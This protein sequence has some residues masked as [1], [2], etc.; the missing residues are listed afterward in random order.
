MH[1]AQQTYIPS[2]E[3]GGRRQ[4]IEEV[5]HRLAVF[6]GRSA[7]RLSRAV[8]K[9]K[10]S[11]I[12]GRVAMRTDPGIL[13]YLGTTRET[14]LVT[15]TNGKSTTSRL[16]AAALSGRGPVATGV[17][18]NRVAGLVSTLVEAPRSAT[19]ALETREIDACGVIDALEP[20]VVILLNLSSDVDK[21]TEASALE[22]ELRE[23]LAAHPET[24]L[25]ANCDDV[26]IASIAFDAAHVVWVAAGMGNEGVT[27]A[28]PRC[29]GL[30][31]VRS[32]EGNEDHPEWCCTD[33]SF[34]R[35]R[36]SWSVERSESGTVLRGPDGF[37]EELALCLPGAVNQ[38]NAAQAV[39]AAAA[40]GVDPREALRAVSS[41]KDIEQRYSRLPWGQHV[42]RL[43]LGKNPV[44]AQESVRVI[45]PETTGAVLVLNEQS[46]NSRDTAWIWDVDY[47]TLRGLGP[48]ILAC[49][50]RAADLSV[51]LAY[52]GVPHAV[53]PETLGA[54]ASCDP[55]AVDVVVP[56]VE[57]LQSLEGEV[58]APRRRRIV[59]GEG[60]SQPR[61]ARLLVPEN[62]Q[63]VPSSGMN[64]VVRIGLILPETL[65]ASGDRGNALVL[66]ERLR[67]RGYDAQILA[68]GF[69][70]PVPG[71]LD[72]YVLGG[73][74]TDQQRLAVEHLRRD[75]GLLRAIEK[76]VPV[77][78]VRAG[79]QIL[80]R[81]FEDEQG[82]RHD[83]LGVLDMT[84]IPT[85]R[86][87]GGAA[88]E[89]KCSPLLD[90]LSS[91]LT[92]LHS[93]PR[94]FVL[95]PKTEPL[96]RLLGETPDLPTRYE[97][98][99][100]GAIIATSL[101]GPVL[102]RN[103]ELADLLIARALGVDVGELVPLEMDCVE[104]LRA[105]RLVAG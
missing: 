4:G 73:N 92:G 9:G 39:A 104:R 1:S 45:D 12:G 24:T 16:L 96:A 91:L 2:N 52:D 46:D 99:V 7:S 8:G 37:V 11:M 35:P 61:G 34:S 71:D 101:Q 81:W 41:V 82:R 21:D 38:G 30:I 19:A 28:C 59:A 89:V 22:R 67:L 56:G 51:R 17:G 54:I 63:I 48:E 76:G 87:P 32:G 100:Q 14:V 69:D 95:G 49:G 68:L 85:N 50:D 10:G 72:L 6:L 66:R 40:M 105:E 36:P 77:L 33:C 60:G 18:A 83:G 70:D 58:G 27:R 98:I 90:D 78:A 23:R 64:R 5:R 42:V 13:E 55:G 57:I 43:L 94:R 74:E 75:L 25:V 62:P 86:A 103:P 15:G 47:T 20:A 88:V 44:A 84:T 93:S 53:V 97:G 3:A 102:A 26:R 31:S 80:G 79:A 65:A 29:A